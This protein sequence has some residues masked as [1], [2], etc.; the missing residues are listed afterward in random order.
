MSKFSIILLIIIIF[1]IVYS[2]KEV[3][4]LDDFTFGEALNNSTKTQSKLFIIFYAR[5]CPYCD[6]SIQ[7]LKERVINYF[8]DEDKVDFAIV[9]LNQQGNLWL[10]IRFNITQ[11]PFIILIENNRMYPFKSQ[12]EENTVVKFINEEK[13]IEDSLEIPGEVNYFTKA[14]LFVNE[15]TKKIKKKMESI[16]Q[17]YGIKAYW[18]N[19]MT[20]I[21]LLSIIFFIIYF[22]TKL[23]SVSRNIIDKNVKIEGL[24]KKNGKNS[25]AKEEKKENEEKENKKEKETE[26]KKENNDVKNIEEGNKN[27]KQKKD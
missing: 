3:I 2:K 6:H 9:N 19:T 17:K 13:T 7:I 20:L 1:Q 23:F 26:D 15:L 5:K 11:I 10:T 21:V 4:T 24:F 25:D 8:K 22:E 18:N 14:K 27:E 12:F 16:L